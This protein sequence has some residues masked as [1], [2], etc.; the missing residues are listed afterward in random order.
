MFCSQ[1]E[2][3]IVTRGQYLMLKSYNVIV[4]KFL[5]YLSLFLNSMYPL[6]TGVILAF[7]STFFKEKNKKIN[8]LN[9]I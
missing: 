6:M 8:Y 3:I 2:I 5:I 1:I 9:N 7:C 4:F